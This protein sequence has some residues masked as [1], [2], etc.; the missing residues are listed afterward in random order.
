VFVDMMIPH[1]QGA[2]T[3]SDVVFAKGASLAVKQLAEQI[4]NSQLGEIRNMRAFREALTGSPDPG[5]GAGTPLHTHP[6][7][8][9]PHPH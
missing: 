1:H 9:E 2:V 8:T 7:D 5:A 4:S 3:M 6:G